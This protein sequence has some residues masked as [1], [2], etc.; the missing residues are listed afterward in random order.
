MDLEIVV[1]DGPTGGW[2]VPLK[3]LGG[4][5]GSGKFA[6]PLPPITI[7]REAAHQMVVSVTLLAD[8]LIGPGVPGGLVSSAATGAVNGAVR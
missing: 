1:V 6:P 7:E 8:S 3:P 4:T 5:D 2:R